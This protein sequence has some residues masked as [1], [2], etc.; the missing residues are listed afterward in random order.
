VRQRLGRAALAH[1]PHE[2]EAGGEERRGPDRR[3]DDRS[4]VGRPHVG[5]VR[6]VVARLEASIAQQPAQGEG[7]VGRPQRR[8]VVE[9]HA[10]AQ[11]EQ[12]RALVGIGPALGERGARLEGRVDVEQGLVGGVEE[13]AR[14]ARFPV[15]I[16]ARERVRDG[17]V[18]WQ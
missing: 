3:H 15:G 18:R 2:R 12:P 13:G 6:Q 1:H 5:D 16:E 14:A 17:D 7:D 11:A 4:L 9:A 10:I 8:S